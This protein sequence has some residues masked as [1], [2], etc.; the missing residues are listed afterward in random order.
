MNKGIFKN[1]LRE[2]RLRLSHPR[3]LVYQEL[4]TAPIPLSPQE[5]YHSLLRSRRKVGLTSI[6]RSL[7]LFESLGIAFKI[8]QGSNVKYKLPS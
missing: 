7:D 2:K 3:L 1:I 8:V 5:L 4:S 6:Y